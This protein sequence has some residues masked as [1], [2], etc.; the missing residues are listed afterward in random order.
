MKE[1]KFFE[2]V[3]EFGREEARVELSRRHVLSVTQ[4]RF[5]TAVTQKIT[6]T[7]NAI[8]DVNRLEELLLSAAT[9]ASAAELEIE[10]A[11]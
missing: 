10:I 7:V 8:E 5:G 4:R 1:S 9:C 2:E 3:K 6:P 11:R